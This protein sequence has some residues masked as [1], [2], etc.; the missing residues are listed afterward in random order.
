MEKE[1]MP[2]PACKK[3]RTYAG[4]V[5]YYCRGTGILPKGGFDTRQ[6]P[7]SE[8][9][10]ID[11]PMENLEL[12]M[13]KLLCWLNYAEKADC[14][15]C[16]YRNQE[17]KF[18]KVVSLIQKRELELA[19]KQKERDE[20]LKTVIISKTSSHLNKFM[21]MQLLNKIFEIDNDKGVL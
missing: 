14:S 15:M 16:G 8:P 7:I 17:C 19:D 18:D 5:C 11:V 4:D 20:R 6:K 10:H 3:G 13:W 21:I 9:N 12:E 1:I 2:C